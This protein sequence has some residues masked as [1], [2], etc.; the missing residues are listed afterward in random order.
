VLYGSDAWTNKVQHGRWCTSKSTNLDVTAQYTS[1]QCLR[2]TLLHP[3]H[4]KSGVIFSDIQWD[5]K[6]P[7]NSAG[8]RLGLRYKPMPIK[9]GKKSFE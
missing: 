8:L 2:W 9:G 5:G 3:H 6:P 1:G 7:N 4:S